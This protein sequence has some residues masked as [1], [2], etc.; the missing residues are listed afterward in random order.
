MFQREACFDIHVLKGFQ[1][2]V[3]CGEL[4]L[5]TIPIYDTKNS[6]VA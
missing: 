4:F 5:K 6:I 2:T 1:Q 3:S